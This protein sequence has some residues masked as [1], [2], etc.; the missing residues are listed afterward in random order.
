M[1][2]KYIQGNLVFALLAILCL[3]CWAAEITTTFSNWKVYPDSGDCGGQ[4]LTLVQDS[5]LR[6]IRG[7][8]QSYVGNCEATKTPIENI[9]MDRQLRKLSFAA[10]EYVQDGKGGLDIAGERRFSGTLTKSRI[11]GTIRYCSAGS[12]PCTSSEQIFL[13]AVARDTP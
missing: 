3:P 10:P 5:K 1:R 11:K 13:R 2:L 12:K 8:L 6:V 9:Q 7:Y 4:T